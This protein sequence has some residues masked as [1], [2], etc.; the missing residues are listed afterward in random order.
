MS[1]FYTL[2]LQPCIPPRWAQGGHAQTVWGHLLPSPV[3]NRVGDRIEIELS[4]GDRLVGRWFRGQRSTTLTAFHGLGGSTDAGYMRRTTRQALE[5]GLNVLLMNHRGSGEGR[6][7]ARGTPHSGRAEDIAAALA[8]A[9]KK[10]PQDQQIALGFS[11]SANALLL[12]LAGERGTT[13]P[14]FAIAVNAPLDLGDAALRLQ[15]GF[16]RIYDTRFVNEC[17]RDMEFRRKLGLNNLTTTVPWNATLRDFDDLFT[18]PLNG[19]E[20]REDYYSRCSAKTKLNAIKTPTLLLTS[21]D[22]PFVN[23]KPYTDSRLSSSIRLH[24]EAYGGHMGY[25]TRASPSGHGIRWLDYAIR[26]T[27]QCIAPKNLIRSF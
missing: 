12:L 18:A 14:D 4:D 13:L 16:N 24:I 19:F 5:L 15:R 6:G 21:A 7:L 20:N 17:R 1:P 8:W 27:L 26:E 23:V 9:R 25:L 2:S 11:M 22:D 3:L 10:H